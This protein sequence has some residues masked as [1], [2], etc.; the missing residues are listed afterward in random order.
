MTQ[1][2]VLPGVVIGQDFVLKRKLKE[3][4]F[5][6]V[7]QAEQLS[8]RQ[9]RAIK[10]LHPRIAAS[11]PKAAERFQIEATAAARVRSEHVVQVVS[12]G[13][14]EATGSLWIA[15]E[16]LTGHDLGDWMAKNRVMPPAQVHTVLQHICHALGAA[17]R[18]NI[19]H[20]DLKPEN[21]FLAESS[22]V[23]VEFTAKVLDFGI[24]KLLAE[25]L[26][27]TEPM[28]TLA[29]LAPE[30][31]S[32][33]ARI[34]PATDVWALGLLA[35]Y[36]LTGRY[37]WLSF[38]TGSFDAGAFMRELVLERLEPASAR[39]A[40]LGRAAYI[41]P[42]FDAW[43]G[44]CVN[45]DARFLNADE[46]HRALPPLHGISVSDVRTPLDGLDVPHPAP[47][48]PWRRTVVGASIG[49][50]L[51]GLI[52]YAS[53][54]SSSRSSAE[55][56]EM[57][58]PGQALVPTP[59]ATETTV[60]DAGTSPQQAGATPTL[61]PNFTPPLSAASNC[62][63]TCGDDC[64]HIMF[65]TGPDF[66]FYRQLALRQREEHRLCTEI[67][68]V[69]SRGAP[70]EQFAY[71]IW[72]AKSWSVP[73]DWPRDDSGGAVVLDTQ[74][75]LRAPLQV[76]RDVKGDAVFPS[77]CARQTVTLT[78]EVGAPV[79]GDEALQRCGARPPAQ[80]ATKDGVWTW[81]G[82]AGGTCSCREDSEEP[83]R[84]AGVGTCLLQ[85]G[86]QDNACI[87]NCE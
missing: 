4:G 82:Q 86:T 47:P 81:K 7:F 27:P 78:P 76:V 70:R 45:R 41:P 57:S 25:T 58:P 72:E 77:A 18:V 51:V 55:T 67:H 52:A 9:L 3:G 39:A 80:A 29:W 69:R 83:Q 56:P 54:Q 21:V 12:S 6:A 35:F 33:G 15:M 10:I 71:S 73:N 28:G 42:G 37:Y 13:V 19:V 85:C 17:H 66:A 68:R 84:L 23:G 74:V 5:G 22:R 46:A 14:D 44:R 49:A 24:A 34:E 43:F 32:R 53:S 38:Q 1:P 63:A 36:L 79:V 59:T 64:R 2:I 50:G 75:V 30:Q 8:T 31:T 20:R 11:N 40:A 62:A 65:A 16:Y 60:E 48:S 26:Q 87:Q 61:D